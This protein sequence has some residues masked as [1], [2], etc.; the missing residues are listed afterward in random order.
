[1]PA[2]GVA[3]DTGTVISWLKNEGAS[4]NKG[5]PL[6][7]VET[8]K[9]TVEL[10]S[11]GS[12]TLVQVSAA[13][14]DQVPVGT[15]IAYIQAVGESM[16]AERPVE[17]ADIAVSTASPRDDSL[18]A[19]ARADPSVPQGTAGRY[20]ASP[21]V[22]RLAAE[23]GIDLATVE[24]SGP[25]GA[26]LTADLE[27]AR[28]SPRDL[29]RESVWRT[30]AANVTQSW[31]A[32][33]HFYLDREVLAASLVAA[34]NRVGLRTTYTDLLV[35]IVARALR[36]HPRMNCGKAHIGI[37]IATGT[38]D[39][40]FVPVLVDADRLSLAEVTS[41]RA[42]LVDRVRSSR[43]TARD[44]AGATFTISNLGM[45]GVD[46]F[47][48]IVSDGQAGYLGVGR[49]TER[50]VPR[51]GAS[52]VASVLSLSLSC[53]HRVVDGMRAAEFLSAVVDAVEN[54]NSLFY[55]VEG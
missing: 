43:H 41:Q 17:P 21:K 5:E 37:G 27:Q 14:G 13:E 28:T 35:T 9:S 15:V 51:D 30:M 31:Q 44:L 3:Q 45:Y 26:I 32:V 39:G 38:P 49:I 52:V 42:Q 48:A 4:V 19:Q 1:M 18:S 24:G 8:D 6:M 7:V 22:R 55:P 20:F 10:E 33:P 50:V 47:H 2:L 11:P 36:D 29:H 12:G 25:E 46:S 23:R 40:L 34:R 16:P 53:D 54:A